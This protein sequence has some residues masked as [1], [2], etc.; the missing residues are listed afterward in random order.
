M[1]ASFARVQSSK[2]AESGGGRSER[3]WS[4]ASGDVGSAEQQN[5]QCSRFTCWEISLLPH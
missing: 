3:K 5:D 1:L 2:A 4:D